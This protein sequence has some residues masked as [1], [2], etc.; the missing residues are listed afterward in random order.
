M[1]PELVVES[2][3]CVGESPRWDSRQHCLWWLDNERATVHRHSPVSG[4]TVSFH[5]PQNATSL[6]LT[7]SD[8]RLLA[9]MDDGVYSLAPDGSALEQLLRMDTGDR[10]CS[11]NDSGCDAHGRLWVG[12]G[13]ETVVGKGKLWVLSPN[14]SETT[15]AL[16]GLS[17]ANGIGFSPDNRFMYLVDSITR[18][19]HRIAYE[20]GTAPSARSSPSVWPTSPMACRTG[21]P[22]T[23]KGVS[24]SPSGTLDACAAIRR[25]EPWTSRFRFLSAA[26][27]A[28]PS[29]ARSSLTCT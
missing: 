13:S 15:V 18:V 16:D 3:D 21:W 20:L 11:F 25:P 12:S 14:A 1:D 4:Q 23:S 8:E 29:V 28:V 22:S 10:G 24:G 6:A 17:L 9:T 26:L 19:V 5:L 27:P 2:N 7:A